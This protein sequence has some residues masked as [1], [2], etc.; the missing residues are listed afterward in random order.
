MAPDIGIEYSNIGCSFLRSAKGSGCAGHLIHRE[1]VPLPLKGKD[2]SA[3][4]DG[5]VLQCRACSITLREG[6]RTPPVWQPFARRNWIVPRPAFASLPTFMRL[7][8]FPYEGKGGRLRW[9][10][11]AIAKHARPDS[12]ALI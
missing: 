12:L 11:S 9:M 6:E 5:R 1:A 7:K 4:Q 3:L 10:R 2:N 8:T